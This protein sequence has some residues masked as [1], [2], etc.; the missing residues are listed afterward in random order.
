MKKI[1]IFF[2][3]LVLPMFVRAEE[4]KF[5]DL[6]PECFKESA[7]FLLSNID[8]VK[9]QIEKRQ[10]LL[11]V[12]N[13]KLLSTR[14]FEYGQEKYLDYDVISVTGAFNNYAESL[15]YL[16][17]GNIDTGLTFDSY[18]IRQKEIVIDAKNILRA[19]QFSFQLN[20]GGELN[21]LYSI[22][23]DN[24]NYINV[25]N[26]DDYDWRY[27][28]I[29][30]VDNDNK[31]IAISK[32]ITI[33]ELSILSNAKQIHLLKPVTNEQVYVYSDYRCDN[34]E[35]LQKA[36]NEAGKN[37]SQENFA[38][39]I[40]TKIYDVSLG[41]NLLYNHD[42][43]NDGIFNEQDN[44]PFVSNKD[45]AD[46]DGDLVGD[47]CD[48]DNTK[49]NY[50]EIDSDH[51][52]VGNSMDNCSYVYNSTQ[53][54][55]NADGVGD[56]C[57]DD[58]GDGIVGYKDNCV[59]IANTDQKDINNNGIGDACEFDKDG[60]GVFDSVDN[61]I[62][63]ANH[64]QIDTDGDGIGDVCDNCN[65]YN[66]QQLDMDS[67]GKGDVC[68]DDE[69]NK[70]N[71][72]EDGDG[73]LDNLDNCRKIANPQQEDADKDGVGDACDNCLNLKNTSQEDANENNVGDL[74][75]DVDSD[76]IE[77]YLDNCPYNANPKQE[78]R[79]N[80]GVGDVC[81]DDDNDNVV[82]INDN[83]PFD[84]NPDQHD[85]DNDGLGDVC[86]AKDN[87]FIESNKTFFIVLVSVI[88]LIF[89][90]LIIFMVK[91]ITSLDAG[92]GESDGK[93]EEPKDEIK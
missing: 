74:C 13:N 84:Y 59:N 30:F 22:S 93:K 42:I 79:D 64:G 16:K 41:L 31:Q 58:D 33:R 72:D 87:R 91:R 90:G 38:I 62:S 1:I 60:D 12:Q 61:C 24:V 8:A 56:L 34:N 5:S 21:P 57:A 28:K 26:V 11:F 2:A 49:K 32:T 25:N 4:I 50:N 81:V 19:G 53:L 52:G 89:V 10:A 82:A 71:N 67:N 17:D 15:K 78:D 20:Y 92:D 43:D 6:K 36:L 65:L 77:G 44:C 7:S 86:D 45:Q 39:D 69:K 48:F 88:S 37:A 80:N 68:D 66:P 29:I 46:V 55:S 35:M 3:L 18:S 75:E 51:D 40:N 73:I 85:I 76:G 54:D 14:I 9:V 27:L 63:I 23:K 47:A 70:K 83:C